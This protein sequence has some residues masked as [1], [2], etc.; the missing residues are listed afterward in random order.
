MGIRKDGKLCNCFFGLEELDLTLF[1]CLRA[2]L[3]IGISPLSAQRSD[4]AE[5][6][7]I[8]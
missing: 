6:V 3:E 4:I 1:S 5:H 8:H 7:Q 2:L